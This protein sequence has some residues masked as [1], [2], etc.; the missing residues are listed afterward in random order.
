MVV[1]FKKWVERRKAV[2]EIMYKLLKYLDNPNSW[3]FDGK[4]TY[5]HIE[6][7]I[8]I[9]FGKDCTVYS[10]TTVNRRRV[11]SP[12]HYHIPLRFKKELKY[13]IRRINDRDR[14][15]NDLKFFDEYMDGIYKQQIKIEKSDRS[16]I[17]I[18]ML[19]NGITEWHIIDCVIWFKT[20]D[21]A[22]AVKLRWIDG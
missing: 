17:T 21:D 19:E 10:D 11:T 15:D 14:S 9:E 16:K 7:G 20:D 18:W 5:R 4:M 22:V 12:I 1:I 2:N 8:I 3:I 6:N 13:R